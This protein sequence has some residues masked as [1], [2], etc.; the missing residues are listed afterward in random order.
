[1]SVTFDFQDNWSYIEQNIT[2]Y[3][4][5]HY[6]E[7]GYKKYNPGVHFQNRLRHKD[8]LQMLEKVGFNV[9]SKKY[10]AVEEADLE[11]LRN[12]Y[13]H[14]SFNAYTL[15]EIGIIDGEIVE[16]K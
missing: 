14:F 1:M 10:H 4:F 12:L 2:G 7:F 6:N 8:Y 15:E 5:L 16:R 3:N 9:V 11:K 13:I